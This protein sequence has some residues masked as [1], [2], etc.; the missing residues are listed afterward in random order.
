MDLFVDVVQAVEQALET[1]ELVA[2]TGDMDHGIVTLLEAALLLSQFL[3][4]T[5]RCDLDL[6][7][8]AR[9]NHGFTPFHIPDAQQRQS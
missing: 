5:E 7:V 3:G 1:L 9:H 6:D 2:L 4:E 8:G